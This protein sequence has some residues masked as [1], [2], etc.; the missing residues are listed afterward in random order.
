MDENTL[1]EHVPNQGMIPGKQRLMRQSIHDSD[2]L[3]FTEPTH[4]G[5]GPCPP[6]HF[7]GHKR[8]R[9]GAF[10]ADPFQH[11]KVVIRA[12]TQLPGVLIP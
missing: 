11:R 7:L 1:S 4:S 9:P 2:D 8:D 10:T 5:I 12:D 6:F 3:S